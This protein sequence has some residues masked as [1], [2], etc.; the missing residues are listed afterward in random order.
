M[1]LES[2]SFLCPIKYTQHRNTTKKLT[3]PSRKVEPGTSI[4]PKIVRISMTDHDATDSSSDEEEGEFYFGRRRVKKYINE[5]SIETDLR[6]S[7]VITNNG[8]KRPA[9]ETRP[10]TRRPAQKTTPCQPANGGN[11]KF[12]GVRQRP[13]GKWAAEIRDPGKRVRLWLGT[14]DTAE[15]AAM[16]YD[17]AA[18]KL[19]GPDA[20]TNFSSPPQI[21][22]TAADSVDAKNIVNEVE[23]EPETTTPNVTVS[24]SG[25]DSGEETHHLSSPTSVLQFRTHSMD[26]AEQMEKPSL[27]PEPATEKANHVQEC[28]V[29]QQLPTVLP[30]MEEEQED[31]FRFP[32]PESPIFESPLFYESP[33]FDDTAVPGPLMFDDF[34]DLFRMDTFG[35]SSFSAQTT[36]S[37]MCQADDCFQDIFGSD[38]LVVL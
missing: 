35:P 22:V 29:Q 28:Q 31:G 12:R 24:V 6:T 37:M 25:Y 4:A 3:K 10:A 18:I 38:P 21:V 26:D 33:F 2:S 19:R 32:T 20:Q 16:V 1:E 15:E 30:Y 7:P 9:L 8:R 23:I 34:S 14:F 11:R 17:N 36:S 5:I 27:Q 13:W